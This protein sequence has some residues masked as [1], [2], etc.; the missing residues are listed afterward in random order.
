MLNRI[1][2][3]DLKEL[4]MKTHK[5]SELTSISLPE[6]QEDTKWV[7]PPPNED[8]GTIIWRWTRRH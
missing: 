3:Q 6:L 4:K 5:Y 7:L 8:Q 1:E 2:G